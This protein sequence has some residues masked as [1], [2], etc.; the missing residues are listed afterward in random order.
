MKRVTSR[1]AAGALS[2]AVVGSATGG[3]I[4][5]ADD[6]APRAQ[7]AQSGGVSVTPSSVERT[8]KRG[9]VGSVTVKNT[10][11]N[12]L[13]VTV[14]VRPWTQNRSTAIVSLNKRAT[15]APYV[16]ASPT[17]FDLKPGSRKVKLVMRRMTAAGSLYAGIQVFAK[18]KRPK[19]NS[20]N[21]IP[22]WDLVGRLRLHPK[23]KRPNLRIGATDV[24]GRGNGR[25]LIL[26]VRNIGNTL[27]P[28]GGTVR[29][30]G[31]TGRNANIP[32]VGIV[33]GQVVYLK[34]GGFSGMKAG[35]YTATWTVTHGG[36]RFTVKRTFRL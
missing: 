5:R 20:N 11:R 9:T 24:V 32:Q 17:T 19:A 27:D 15:L 23:T 14:T 29:I 34:G 22:Q 28:V 10:T 31:P 6:S 26:A 4:A 18:Q 2:L 25:S 13:R 35:N 16:R 30:T 12:T 21:I 36:K 1:L 7:A 8:A 3:V 33:P